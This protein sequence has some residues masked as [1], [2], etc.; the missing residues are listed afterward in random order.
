MPSC[1]KGG[2]AKGALHCVYGIFDL[3]LSGT[4]IIAH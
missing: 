2:L 3:I 1:A 4:L